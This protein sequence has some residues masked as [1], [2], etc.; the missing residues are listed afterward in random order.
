MFG[1]FGSEGKPDGRPGND[2]SPDGRL[3]MLGSDGSPGM[4]GS[5]GR[6]DGMFGMFGSPTACSA[7]TACHGR[8]GRFGSPDG[9]LGIDGTLGSDGIEGSDGTDGNFGI[10]GRPNRC[11]VAPGPRWAGRRSA[12]RTP[13]TRRTR[14]GRP[15]RGS[16]RSPGPS[17]RVLAARTPDR[18]PA[19]RDRHRCR[20]RRRCRG[21]PA[22]THAGVALL[23]AGSG[24]GPVRR[25]PPADRDDLVHRRP[26]HRRCGGC[27][28]GRQRG[29]DR[30]VAEQRRAALR[31]GRP[32]RAGLGGRRRS[33]GRSAQVRKP[34]IRARTAGSPARGPGRA[35]SRR[36]ASR[37]L[38]D[39]RGSATA[40]PVE[41]D[42]RRRRTVLGPMAAGRASGPLA[43]SICT[44]GPASGG[45]GTRCC[46]GRVSGA[47]RPRRRGPAS[48]DRWTTGPGGVGSGAPRPRRRGAAGRPARRT[49]SRA[50]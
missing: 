31:G 27:G 22:A 7:A 35:D 11:T 17:R 41:P 14:G 37:H 9:R 23:T 33:R 6:P 44:T 18:S 21:A 42:G 38:L 46:G 25:L 8:S 3:G 1:M 36:H 48:G 12:R 32:P 45:S 15:P 24:A 20:P 30:V 2:G 10:E 43:G 13:P 28:G 49:P 29:R 40:G 39:D 5:D 19:S 34:E 4:F 16:P 50:G 26:L 47:P